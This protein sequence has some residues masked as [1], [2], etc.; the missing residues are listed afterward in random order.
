MRRIFAFAAL[1]IVLIAVPS[2]RAQTPP[3]SVIHPIQPSAATSSF[4]SFSNVKNFFSSLHFPSFS[5]QPAI[6]QSGLPAP[7]SFPGAKYKSPLVP[8][9]PTTTLPAPYKSPFVPVAPTFT[10]PAPYKSPLIPV[11]LIHP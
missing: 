4:F 1:F 11:A 5:N 3:R 8:V 10:L 2:A 6:G 7:G 9:M